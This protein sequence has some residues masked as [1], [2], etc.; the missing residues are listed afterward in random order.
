[1]VSEDTFAKAESGDAQVQYQLGLAYLYGTDIEKDKV[2]AFYWFARSSG[3][4]YLPAARE[5]GLCYISGEGTDKDVAKG[6]EL[7]EIVADKLDPSALYHLGLLYETGEGVPKDL[8]KAVRYL[9]YAA[10]LGYPNADMDADRVDKV[11]TE[12]RNRNLRAR[13][14]LKLQISDVDVEAACCKKMLDKLLAQDIVFIDSRTG[15]ALLGEDKDGMDAVLECGP[16]CG[17]K[18]E[19]VPHDKKY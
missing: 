3:A 1:M 9:A 6:V 15:P 14:L 13:P 7:L 8:Q 5:L 4:G 18:I 10:E 12:Q 19:L 17:A 11:L 2:K 16:F